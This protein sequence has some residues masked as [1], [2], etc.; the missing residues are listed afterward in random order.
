MELLHQAVIVNPGKNINITAFFLIASS[1]NRI[2]LDLMFILL[3]TYHISV[4]TRVKQG[5]L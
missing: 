3:I 4:K 1:A 5:M 2:Q